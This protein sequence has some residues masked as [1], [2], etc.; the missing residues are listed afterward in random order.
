MELKERLAN[1]TVSLFTFSYAALQAGIDQ[2]LE[3]H[4]VI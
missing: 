1:N 3:A 4:A 2:L